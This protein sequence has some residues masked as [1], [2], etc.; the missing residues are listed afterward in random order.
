MINA[1]RLFR[2]VWA[3]LSPFMDRSTRR[4]ITVHGKNFS[5]EIQAEIDI[6]T[7][8][9]EYGGKAKLPEGLRVHPEEKQEELI[10]KFEIL[11]PKAQKRIGSGPMRL[12][13]DEK[14]DEDESG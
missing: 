7:I 13:E 12:V 9:V 14:L 8:P 5:K 2:G 1:P 6:D 3:L 11:T 4:K 10:R